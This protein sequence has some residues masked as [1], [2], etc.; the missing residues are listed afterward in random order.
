MVTKQSSQ[1]TGDSK[2]IV[3]KIA[4]FLCGL[5]I[6]TTILLQLYFLNFNPEF[7]VKHSAA[8]NIIS[9]LIYSIVFI[10][11]FLACK[12]VKNDEERSSLCLWG[13]IFLIMLLKNIYFHLNFPGDLRPGDRILSEIPLEVSGAI[14][15]IYCTYLFIKR[16]R[17]KI[18]FIF[19]L[20]ILLILLSSV[21]FP[22]ESYMR[23]LFQQILDS[24]VILAGDL[25]LLSICI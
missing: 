22:L 18:L 19:N 21:L 1:T 8:T 25:I 6:L 17:I 11:I 7:V 5:V 20:C 10:V 4:L 16:V 14:I 9:L 2:S 24:S 3:F 15:G 12:K 13:V 23:M